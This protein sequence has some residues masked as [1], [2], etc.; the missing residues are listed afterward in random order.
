MRAF[1]A[2]TPKTI[3]NNGMRILLVEDDDDCRF[4][5]MLSLESYGYQVDVAANAN[6]AI[7]SLEQR[8]PDL[9]LTD[10]AMPGMSGIELGQYV[11]QRWPH[12]KVIA[13]TGNHDARGLAEGGFSAVV[14]KPIDWSLLHKTIDHILRQQTHSSRR[15]A[16]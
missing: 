15:A 1:G 12:L 4:L 13:V 7:M 9:L 3:M 11:R 8:L 6:D 2:L 14:P 5:S 10:I 16:R